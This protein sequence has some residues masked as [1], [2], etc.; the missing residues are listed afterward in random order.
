M[1]EV[2]PPGNIPGSIVFE[3]WICGWSSP[4]NKEEWG[5]GNNVGWKNDD[6]RQGALSS[7]L[8]STGDYLQTASHEQIHL[9]VE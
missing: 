6:T 2:D 1:H 7:S 8:V 4:S 9:S 3:E 5:I